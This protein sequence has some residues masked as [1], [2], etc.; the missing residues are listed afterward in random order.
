MFFPV[1]NNTPSFYAP[2]SSCIPARMTKRRSPVR[3][4]M[5]AGTAVRSS[6]GVDDEGVLSMGGDR[7]C[8]RPPMPRPRTRSDRPPDAPPTIQ[9]RVYVNT[10]ENRLYPANYFCFCFCFCFWYTHSLL[11]QKHFFLYY[12]PTR[13]ISRSRS[14]S[15]LGERPSR[16]S[17]ICYL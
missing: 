13:S 17:M 1:N 11:L 3:G 2:L 16:P 8:V 15:G 5:L 10:I 14:R 12:G 6:I 7:R 9:T 4:A